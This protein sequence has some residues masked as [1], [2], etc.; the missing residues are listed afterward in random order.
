MSFVPHWFTLSNFMLVDFVFVL[1]LGLE[2]M[3]EKTKIVL[4][5]LPLI[6]LFL[7]FLIHFFY[8]KL[9]WILLCTYV[10]CFTPVILTL[11]ITIIV[12]LVP[13]IGF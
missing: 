2:N 7:T 10:C 5:F 11:L 6:P 13:K 8:P 3:K 1:C 9:K 12:I 4:L